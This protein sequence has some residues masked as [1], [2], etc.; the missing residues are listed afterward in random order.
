MFSIRRLLRRIKRM[1]T[2]QYISIFINRPVGAVPGGGGDP[3]GGEPLADNPASGIEIGVNVSPF[4]SFQPSHKMRK[5]IFH[6]C[7]DSWRTPTAADIASFNYFSTTGTLTSQDSNGYPTGYGTAASAGAVLLDGNNGTAPTGTYV[8]EFDAVGSVS[9]AVQV[10]EGSIKTLTYLDTLGNGNVRVTFNYTGGTVLVLVG[11]DVYVSK[12]KMYENTFVNDD[13]DTEPWQQAFL[14]DLSGFSYIRYLDWIHTNNSVE[15]TSVNL[16]PVDYFSHSKV[17]KSLPIEWM[18]DLANRTNTDMWI[19]IPHLAEQDLIT[20]WVDYIRDNLNPGLKLYLEWSNETWNILFTQ[21]SYI[22][23]QASNPDIAALTADAFT[24]RLYFHGQKSAEMFKWAYD[25]YIAGGRSTDEIVR[26]VAGQQVNTFIAEKNLDGACY[27]G[28]SAFGGV[29]GDL[30]TTAVNLETSTV[31]DLVAIGGYVYYSA[32]YDDTLPVI[33]SGDWNPGTG[34]M[35]GADTSGVFYN[36]TADGTVGGYNFSANHI[37]VAA[38][39]SGF[40]F[41]DPSEE[42]YTNWTDASTWYQASGSIPNT[43]TGN[44][45]AVSALISIMNNDVQDRISDFNTHDSVISPRGIKISIYE[46]GSHLTPSKADVPGA[47]GSPETDPELRILQLTSSSVGM[48]N[49]YKDLI[50]GLS[51]I[52]DEIKFSHFGM[53]T[54]STNTGQFGFSEDFGLNSGKLDALHYFIE[55][56]GKE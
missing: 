48:E 54:R 17:T 19:P 2:N 37:I 39:A 41:G 50:S 44:D 7:Q 8:V 49:I 6:I 24:G 5:D 22:I 13:L 46:G 1:P 27:F 38:Q 36:V 33:F 10:W 12:I 29:G 16:N 53:H 52:N 43:M 45:A 14:D 26:V 40:A 28:A 30:A 9:G 35:P 25:S 42:T 15:D 11:P 55:Q 18:V 3:G 56:S 4:Y 32:S 34:S 51:A 23:N 20:Y 21:A 31:V 47:A